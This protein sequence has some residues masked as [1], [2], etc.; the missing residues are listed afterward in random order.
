MFDFGQLSQR[1]SNRPAIEPEPFAD[2]G[3]RHSKLPQLFGLGS[4]L[5]IDRRQPG[6]ENGHFEVHGCSVR[7]GCRQGPGH[8]FLLGSIP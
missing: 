4:D 7:S 2:L 6:L 3:V 5:L 8:G 1:L